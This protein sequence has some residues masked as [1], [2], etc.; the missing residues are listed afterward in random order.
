[1][2]VAHRICFP[3]TDTIRSPGISP[4][5]P[6]TVRIIARVVDG[7][8]GGVGNGFASALWR[9]PMTTHPGP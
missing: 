2:G 7:D 3:R 1:M 5:E 6:R 9:L 8:G 4:G